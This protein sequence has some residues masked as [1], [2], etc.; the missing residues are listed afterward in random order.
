VIAALEA[1]VQFAVVYGVSA[2]R[3]RFLDLEPAE[4]LL[5]F[6]PLDAA[7]DEPP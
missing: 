6:R 1:D 4:R 3:R 7:S 2:N 5:G